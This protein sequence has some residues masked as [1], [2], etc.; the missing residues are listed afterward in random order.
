LF[1]RAAAADTKTTATSSQKTPHQQ[2]QKQ[3]STS[4]SSVTSTPTT[5]SGDKGRKRTY[6]PSISSDSTT[7]TTS[8]TPQQDNSRDKPSAP[9]RSK[10]DYEQLRSSGS[11]TW[12]GRKGHLAREC[13]TYSAAIPPESDKSSETLSVN[14]SVKRQKSFDN[15]NKKEAQ[16]SSAS[17]N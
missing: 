1:T 9:W 7:P 2:Q 3:T 5:T 13:M 12:C 6:R 14:Q 17:K 11:C 8:S 10:E 4:S 15:R 16:D